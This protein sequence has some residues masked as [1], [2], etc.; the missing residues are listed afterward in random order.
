[1]KFRDVYILATL[2]AFIIPACAGSEFSS[3]VVRAEIGGQTATS[4]GQGGR[5]GAG[6]PTLGSGGDASGGTDS[7]VGSSTV[8]SGSQGGLA[9]SGGTQNL[10]GSVQS[11][12]KSSTGGATLQMNSGGTSEPSSGGKSSTNYTGGSVT[13]GGSSSSGGTDAA[14]GRF[15][16]VHTGGFSQTGG[17]VSTGGVASSGGTTAVSSGWSCDSGHYGTDDGC[18]CGCGVPDPDCGGDDSAGICVAAN[19]QGS[20]GRASGWGVF[21]IVADDNTRCISI[22]SG[23]TCAPVFFGDGYCHCGCGIKDSDCADEALESCQVCGIPG[24]CSAFNWSSTCETIDPVD[25]AKCDTTVGV[26]AR[27]TCSPGHYGTGDG[28]DCGC[29]AA[30]PDCATSAIAI[31]ETCEDDGACSHFAG[32]G[33]LRLGDNAICSIGKWRCDPN[34]M[35]A[36]DGCDCGCGELDPDCRDSLAESCDYCVSSGSCAHSCADIDS[37]TNAV[38]S[39]AH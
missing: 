21:A 6:G 4:S 30:D 19:D 17:A 29:G 34:K 8:N 22:P 3:A 1:M 33:Q 9:S 14:G 11:G 12:G 2:I 7:R 15:T 10:G 32:C 16:K 24:S 23:W 35:G 20:C 26:P 38:C 36:G 25:N 5:S 31:C 27:W 37:N 13:T 18:D 39:P 28:C